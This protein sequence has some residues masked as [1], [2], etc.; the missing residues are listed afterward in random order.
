MR[1]L[2]V[3]GA[4]VHQQ[5]YFSHAEEDGHNVNTPVA[6]LWE[7]QGPEGTVSIT[8]P[9]RGTIVSVDVQVGDPVHTG[10]QV[11]VLEAMKMEFIVEAT[12]SGV[13]RAVAASVGDTLSAGHA[14]LYLGTRHAAAIAEGGTSRLGI[15][16]S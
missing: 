14:L 12:S 15:H 16:R 6:A 5:L 13:V 3:S 10:Q 9:H 11:A 1:E 4:D 7:L 2:H 8:A